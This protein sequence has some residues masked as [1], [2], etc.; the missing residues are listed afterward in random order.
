[1]EQELTS[2]QYD[3]LKKQQIENDPNALYADSMREEK[4]ANVIAQLDPQN[5]LEGIEYKLRGQKFNKET[6]EWE[7]IGNVKININEVLISR[8][9]SFLGSVLN[10]NT[11]LSNYSINEINNRM[12]LV[13]DY[14]RDDLSDNDV[15]YGLV[16]NYTEMTRIGMIIC[17]TVSSVF[18]R[19]LNGMESRRIFNALK[20][21]ES[22]TQAPQNQTMKE[23]F[24]FWK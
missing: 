23:A 11:T 19:A 20:V 15:E 17:E 2:K 8:L 6:Q 7:N 18:R 24:K 4:V 12:E 22:L 9:M 21:T 16:G 3:D 14:I 10:Q 5:L 1:M 13:I